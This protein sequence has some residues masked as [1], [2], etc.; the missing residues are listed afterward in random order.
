MSKLSLVM[1]VKNEMKYLSRC[2][3]SVKDIVDEIVIV[4]TGSTDRTKEIAVEHGAKVFDYTWDHHF[5]NARNFALRQATGDWNMVLDADEYIP[6]QNKEPI[7]S[8]IENYHAIGRLKIVSRFIDR[9]EEKSSFAYMSR[10]FP[11]GV[12]YSGAIHE[13]ISS[14]LPH[15][16]LPITV[17][18]DGYLLVSE[19]KAK[20]N[21]SLLLEQYQLDSENPY[22][23]YQLAKEYKR[24][25]DSN[26]AEKFF[27][28]AYN[29]LSG[30]EGYFPV[31]IID[32]IYTL[33]EIGHLATCHQV[34]QK[35]ESRLDD[36]PDFHFAR[37]LFY[38]EYLMKG[39]LVEP[40][41]IFLIEEAFKKCIRIGESTQYDSV[42]G[43]GS[44]LAYYNLGVFYEVV[45][46]MPEAIACYQ[47]SSQMKYSP[48]TIRL[49]RLIG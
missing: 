3:N 24:S 33:M 12:Y 11:R 1:I 26:M 47:K 40:N 14:D 30:T 36:Y 13:Q 20:R 45:G 6:D 46:N 41:Q 49:N 31:F 35:N 17:N 4:D 9:G 19:E 39:G 25:D 10:L 22:I 34:I 37:G 23:I 27:N 5:A 7:R 29:M 44:F 2:L 43:T 8:F 42:V 21:I 16:R 18:H 32:Y 28:K 38:M 15:Y 48:A